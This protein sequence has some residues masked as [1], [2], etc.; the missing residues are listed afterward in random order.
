L[1]TELV[2]T[3]EELASLREAWNALQ[4]EAARTS[5][6]ATWEWQYHWW[7]AY[8]R[9]QRL[10]VVLVRDED[11]ALLGILPLYVQTLHPFRGLS[12]RVLRF[13]GTGGD[14]D[15]DDLGPVLGKGREEEVARALAARV[16]ALWGWDGLLLTDMHPEEPLAA[17]L[18][19]AAPQAGVR[20]SRGLSAR[21]AY[22]ELPA[23]WDLYLQSL[24]RER[25]WRVRNSR[26]KLEAQVAA[27]F[28]V[29]ENAETLDQ[30]VDRLVELHHARWSAAGQRHSFSSPEYVA[31]HRGVMR[32]C[33]E[34]GWLRLYCLEADGRVIAMYYFYRFR[35]QV[36][37]M[38]GGFDPGYSRLSPG[39]VLLGHAL[40]HAIGEGNAAL[41][42]LRGEHQYK[43]ELASASR[44]TVFLAG[45]RR[46]LGGRAFRARR[47]HVPR[48][49]G[50][51][52]RALLRAGL[53][54]PPAPH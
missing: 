15:P 9:G 5:V 25:R 33:L 31:C 22:L 30:A 7:R 40:E 12:T 50:A 27:R 17:A 52:K 45:Y 34:R 32:A 21:I 16:I 36:F 2:E 53:W 29:W 51:V 10:C 6:F 44:D 18:V 48:L 4:D 42:F 8:G 43:D 35:N 38:Q 26:K 28:F 20:V 14:T 13:V 46:S 1:K 11:G 37:L 19:A 49:K 24:S 39:R 41:D 47:E 23:S 3:T 54:K